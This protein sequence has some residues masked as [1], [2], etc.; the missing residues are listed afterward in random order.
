MK[1]SHRAGFSLLEVILAT[2]ILLGAAVVLAELASV[3]REHAQRAQEL[4]AAQLA[5]QT[6]LNE[7][8]SGSAPLQSVQDQAL[9]DPPGWVR[10]VQV[11]PLKRSGQVTGLLEVRVTVSQ[12]LGNDRRGKEFTLTRWVGDPSFQNWTDQAD[13]WSVPDLFGNSLEGELP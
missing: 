2:A 7:V 6:K 5:A 4:A 11:G 10:S 13:P 12:E 9:E 8:L 1:R 3:G